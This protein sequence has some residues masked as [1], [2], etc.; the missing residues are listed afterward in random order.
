MF[1][2]NGRRRNE[3]GTVLIVVLAF[4]ALIALL[5]TSFMTLQ[6]LEQNVTENYLDH[7]RAKNTAQ[8][9]VDVAV[10]KLTRL[11]REGWLQDWVRENQEWIYFGEETNEGRLYDLR[12]NPKE[13][14]KLW[15]P[16]RRAANP[17]FALE[18]DNPSDPEDQNPRD[19][20]T[21]PWPVR[22]EGRTIGISGYSGGS[23]GRHGNVYSLKVID[24][25]SQININDGADLGNS[26]SVSQNLRRILNILGAQAAV[27]IAKL[28]DKIIDGRPKGGYKTKLD[29]LRV[30]NY[31]RGQ[32][33]K[34]RDLITV[35]SWRN[36]KVHNPVPLSKEEYRP[37]VYPVHPENNALPGDGYVRPNR[38]A[39][40]TLYR[41][42]HGRDIYGNIIDHQQRPWPL[43]FFNPNL[44]PPMDKI[45]LSRAKSFY[46]AVWAY[47]ALNP[48]W[49]EV[50][51]RSPV[52]VNTATREVLMALVTDLEGFFLVSRRRPVP[53]EAYYGWM[54]HRYHYNPEDGGKDPSWERRG[55]EIGYLY[56]T[57]PFAGPGGRNWTQRGAKPDTI[58]A[59]RIVDEIMACRF[60]RPSPNIRGL[61]Y[62]TAPFGG[63]FRSWQQ[64][65]E[66]VDNLVRTGLIRDNRKIYWDYSPQVQ[67]ASSWGGFTRVKP[68]T[69]TS[70]KLVDS[71]VQR[72]IAS[73]AIADVLKANFNPNLTLNE[74]NPDR[75]LF[76][77]VDKTDLLV[78]STEFCFVPMG[79]FEIESLGMI[80]EPQGDADVLTA[81]DNRIIAESRIL[82]EVRLYEPYYES[83]QADFYQGRF[84]R[85]DRPFPT[86]NNGRATE[87]GPEPDNGPMPLENR[88]SGWVA[89]ATNLGT[90]QGQDWEKP[91]DGAYYTTAQSGIYP[92]KRAPYGSSGGEGFGAA[93]HSH[94]T[95]DHVAH[96]HKGGFARTLHVG[97][98]PNPGEQNALNYPDRTE[99]L[100]NPKV[101]SPYSPIEGPYR[102]EPGKY[103][104]AGSFQV[105]PRNPYSILGNPQDYPPSDLRVDGAYVELHSAFGYSLS[106]VNTSRYLTI[107]FWMK[108]NWF[109]ESTG[110]IRTFVSLSD[111]DQFYRQPYQVWKKVNWR[112]FPRPLPFG[113][114]YLPG[115]HAQ[116]DPW[117]SHYMQGP[118][119]QT[120]IW[121]VGADSAV[122][123]TPGGFGV[124]TP[125]LS[126]EFEPYFNAGAKE[127]YD[128]YRSSSHRGRWNDLRDH[129]WV[130]VMVQVRAGNS[131]TY[132]YPGRPPWKGQTITTWQW[133]TRTQ[134]VLQRVFLGWRTIVIWWRGRK[135]VIQ[136][137][138]WGWRRV[139]VTVRYRV[140]VKK[141]TS[142]RPNLNDQWWW[143][144]KPRLMTL[145]INGRELPNTEQLSVHIDSLWPRLDTVAGDSVRIG[146]EYSQHGQPY[147][148]RSPLWRQVL[149]RAKGKNVK[150]DVGCPAEKTYFHRMYWADATIDEF[151]LWDT[152]P[153]TATFQARRI[154]SLGRYY[155]PL[156]SGRNSPSGDGLFISQKIE[157][158]K[159]RK[160]PDPHKVSPPPG[161]SAG[162]TTTTTATG[163]EPGRRVLAVAWTVYA[164]G[165]AAAGTGSAARRLRPYV[166][167]YMNALAG[168]PPVAVSPG[169]GPDANGFAYETLVQMFIR[170]QDEKGAKREYG[171]YHNEAWSPVREA[172]RIRG[173]GAT[174]TN[175]PRLRA[176]EVAHYVA[177]FR[178]GPAKLLL[179]TPVL[180]DVTVFFE[181]EHARFLTYA[182]LRD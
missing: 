177:K 145:Q 182:E 148:F 138:V 82:T 140:P 87:S 3:R 58:L 60:R 88:Y 74:L 103:R 31:D 39:G 7:V 156:G 45:Q 30:L 62:A 151:Y 126:H 57:V 59:A 35:R 165:A 36:P 115:M 86:T 154:F 11:V 94:F 69:L 147:T 95:F 123:D 41:Y 109:P 137:P 17:S 97:R 73:Q 46:H 139:P 24:C 168:R 43:R 83:V 111:T 68:W 9:G 16:L 155:R 114:F 85:R 136:I 173:G 118:R 1:G 164:E 153:N 110:K 132:K 124:Y 181:E 22:V 105:D 28:G 18:H 71:P 8:S 78:N 64:F 175:P 27:G 134:W 54:W 19:G 84:G 125:S 90:M 21:K 26:H 169:A 56:R 119:N 55:S 70:V 176:K 32:Y 77:L 172:H 121:A 170:I 150:I 107:G 101:R 33:E 80:L 135:R 159:T 143:Y 116:D 37:E 5:A 104:L 149:Y 61:N 163:N 129:E 146:G 100:K 179:A 4:L 167:D 2:V 65:N 99:S 29:V 12:N 178:T 20:Q 53:V 76:T 160:L 15:A 91:K 161:K 117:Q 25:Q 63:P 180:D 75:N 162:A 158:G 52:N 174:D 50:V 10:E 66:F 98:W 34:I 166:L 44:Q 6:T 108:P 51:G 133:R 127:D 112:K 89:L 130:Y 48:Q 49:I 81:A 131:P 72:R 122:T 128:R 14:P 92:G 93:I 42:G 23:Y 40:G 47:D 157:F 144:D 120:L 152:P 141:V 142:G 79:V 13:R 102:G 96:Y 67:K 106:G 171:P 38:R 113:L